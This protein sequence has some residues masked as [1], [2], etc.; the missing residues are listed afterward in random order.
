MFEEGGGVRGGKI[1]SS[2]ARRSFSFLALVCVFP[3][4]RIFHPPRRKIYFPPSEKCGG[5]V[6]VVEMKENGCVF[7]RCFVRN[8]L[9]DPL[10]SPSLQL[11]RC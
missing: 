11:T 3:S 10:K 2:N 4:Y 5:I 6:F 1:Y 7:K 9:R 8:P